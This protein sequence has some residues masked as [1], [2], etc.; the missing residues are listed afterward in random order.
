[1]HAWTFNAILAL[2]LAAIPLIAFGFF[3]TEIVRACQKIPLIGRLILPAIFGVPYI[4]ATAA[5]V[6]A[7]WLAIYLGLPIL[8]AAILHNAHHADPQQ[9]GNWRDF[10]ILL[11]L[12]LAVDLRWFEAA[13]PAPIR[14][15]SKIL[16]LDAGLYGFLV[17]RQLAH[18]GYDLRICLLDLRTGLRELCFYAP[19]AVPL[20]LWLGFLHFHAHVLK[21]SVALGTWLLT[22][23]AIAIPEEIYF[24]GWLQNLLERRLGRR[25]ALAITACIFGLAHFN[26]RG[27][28]FN[29]RYVLLAAIAGIFYG[30]AWR[31]NQR[32]ASS[33]ITHSLVDTIWSLWL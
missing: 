24:R 8:V 4:I 22:F 19:I 20:G 31:Q 15:V 11:L 5:S 12:G 1:V 33:A 26:R 6:K 32:V 13:W 14:V 9:R 21:F 2:V 18:V 17:I 25:S 3:T 29:W 16:L 30:R 10:A 28:R 23:F 27:V 7:A